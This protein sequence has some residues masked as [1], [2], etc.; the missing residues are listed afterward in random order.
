MGGT[1]QKIQSSHL[2][3]RYCPQANGE[4]ES[5]VSIAKKTL[6]QRDPFALV[7]VRSYT[8]HIHRCKPL[9]IDERNR[10]QH[11][12]T[13]IKWNSSSSRFS[14]AMKQLPERMSNLKLHT[15]STSTRDMECDPPQIVEPCRVTSAVPSSANT[16]PSATQPEVFSWKAD[17]FIHRLPNHAYYRWIATNFWGK[18]KRTTSTGTF[19]STS[20]LKT[21]P[22]KIYHKNSTAARM[23]T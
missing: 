21:S 2:S 13:Y 12:P 8:P 17:V 22:G 15:V 6:K 10:H 20:G 14:W 16:Q 4:A 11:P 23:A 9:S 19:H 7:G 3:S 1:P 18:W 5:E